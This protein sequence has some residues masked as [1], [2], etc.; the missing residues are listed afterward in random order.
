MSVKQFRVANAADVL[1]P[2]I[3]GHNRDI[4]K[5][6]GYESQSFER[7]HATLFNCTNSDW[8]SAKKKIIGPVLASKHV[9]NLHAEAIGMHTQ[10]MLAVIC[11]GQSCNMSTMGESYNV[12]LEMFTA[13]ATKHF[14][15]V[16]T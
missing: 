13:N 3:Y 14:V 8:V 7:K 16:L 5:A 9:L 6:K 1:Q 2:V 4:L 15:L 11:S 12:Y 10:R